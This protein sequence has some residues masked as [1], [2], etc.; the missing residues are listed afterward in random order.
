MFSGIFDFISTQNQYNNTNI[1]KL[2]QGIREVKKKHII[3]AL[4]SLVTECLTLRTAK[5]DALDMWGRLL[6]FSRYIPDAGSQG[7]GFRNFIFYQRNFNILKFFKTSDI[8]YNAL[9]DSSYRQILMLLWQSRNQECTIRKNTDIASE[10]LE[11]EVVTGDTMN[12][13]YITYYFRQ[14]LSSW[15]AFVLNNYQILPRPAGVKSNFISAIYKTFGFYT[16]NADYNRKK[17]GNFWNTKFIETDRVFYKN[18]RDLFSMYQ[19]DIIT[20]TQAMINH[21]GLNEEVTQ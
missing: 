2:L 15:L 8:K 16:N 4:N 5:G 13:T 1:E 18:N 12:M 9:T 21:I 7:K 10:V 19:S 17:L 11:A 3:S 14:E 20:I 6:H